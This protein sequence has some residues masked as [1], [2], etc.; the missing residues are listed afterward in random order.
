MTRPRLMNYGEARGFCVRYFVNPGLDIVL[1]PAPF[2]GHSLNLRPLHRYSRVRLADIDRR[3][4]VRDDAMPA[5][6]AG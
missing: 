3:H 5:V 6:P 4:R 2:R 1:V